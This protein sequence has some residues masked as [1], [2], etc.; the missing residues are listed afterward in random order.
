MGGILLIPR[1]RPRRRDGTGPK[2]ITVQPPSWRAPSA[3]GHRPAGS[4]RSVAR[5][6]AALTARWAVTALGASAAG[7]SCRPGR[8]P[9]GNEW[10]GDELVQRRAA[11]VRA[12]D[13]LSTAQEYLE[14]GVAVTTAIL[15]DRHQ[16]LLWTD[17][18]AS[19][20]ASYPLPRLRRRARCPPP[21]RVLSDAGWLSSMA[22]PP[23]EEGCARY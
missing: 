19:T 16:D 23:F 15:I 2:A 6:C 20:A 7:L 10:C 13:R 3:R 4:P 22:A 1:L 21:P 14:T 11:T 17:R 12:D 18:S 8:T 5:T 9:A